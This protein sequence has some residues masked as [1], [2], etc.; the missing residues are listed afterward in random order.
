MFGHSLMFFSFFLHFYV[1]QQTKRSQRVRMYETVI[2]VF[3]FDHGVVPE[4]NK[5]SRLG[6]EVV[7]VPLEPLGIS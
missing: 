6:V 7:L 5:E 2:Y 3:V 4:R 1:S